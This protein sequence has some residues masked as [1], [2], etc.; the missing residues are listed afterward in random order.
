MSLRYI[1]NYKYSTV[2]MLEQFILEQ[3][4]EDH[5]NDVVELGTKA[6]KRDIEIDEEEFQN[7][8]KILFIKND[9]ILLDVFSSVKS[10]ANVMTNIFKDADYVTIFSKCATY[11]PFVIIRMKTNCSC[12]CKDSD[13]VYDFPIRDIF[14][15]EISAKKKYDIIL[16]SVGTLMYTIVVYD[17]KNINRQFNLKTHDGMN[18]KILTDIIN[19]DIGGVQ[20][21]IYLQGMFVDI[22]KLETNKDSIIQFENVDLSSKVFIVVSGESIVCNI[23]KQYSK[24][25]INIAPRTHPL[26][27]SDAHV[28]GT[29]QLEPY[30]QSFKLPYSKLVT[31]KTKMYYVILK[32]GTMLF[33]CKVLAPSDVRIQGKT[34]GEIFGQYNTIT[35][36]YKMN[37]V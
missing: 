8:N 3:I 27:I 24:E 10:S 28:D 14:T 5:R 4:V 19:L 33:F 35:E 25:I 18:K 22:I 32:F 9:S 12:K 7:S 37:A 15:K 31:V 29:Y 1:S 36:G 23:E 6:E 13:L 20:F 30:Q 21:N 11:Y 34:F 16:E 2:R 17:N 26:F